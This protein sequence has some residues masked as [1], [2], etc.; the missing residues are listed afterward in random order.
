MI[1]EVDELRYLYKRLNEDKVH[2]ACSSGPMNLTWKE[3][4]TLNPYLTVN[5]SNSY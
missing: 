1:E 3:G 2:L 5:H 4:S